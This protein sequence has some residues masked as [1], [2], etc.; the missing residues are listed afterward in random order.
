MVVQPLH[1]INTHI[2]FS[3]QPNRI[4]EV[5][6]LVIDNEEGTKFRYDLGLV[7]HNFFTSQSR[8]WLD[9][10]LKFGASGFLL[11]GKY[12]LEVVPK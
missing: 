12:E 7:G 8:G 9:D 5:H 3:R 6:L 1:C 2:R 11:P 10:M 4:V